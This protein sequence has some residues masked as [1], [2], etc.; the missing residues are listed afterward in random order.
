MVLNKVDQVPLTRVGLIADK[1]RKE[2]GDWPIRSMAAKTGKGVKD[3]IT[4]L[5]RVLPRQ[6]PL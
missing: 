4:E 2:L 1:V 5:K 6:A 3:I